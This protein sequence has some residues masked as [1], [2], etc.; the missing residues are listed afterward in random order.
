[1]LKFYLALLAAG[2]LLQAAQCSFSIV[3]N[4]QNEFKKGCTENNRKYSDKVCSQYAEY[5]NRCSNKLVTFPHPQKINGEVEIPR[6]TI[7]TH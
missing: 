6:G 4:Y 2:S 7:Q 1:M 3:D 5:I